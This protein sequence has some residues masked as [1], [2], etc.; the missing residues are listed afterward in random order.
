MYFM[1]KVPEHGFS[2]FKVGDHTVTHGPDGYDVS[3]GFT[4]H[5]FRLKSN[6]QN[7]VF[8][9]VV[10]SYRYHRGLAQHNTFAFHINQGIGS[11]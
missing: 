4:Q 11:P 3:R 2:N 6:S 7:P 9:S 8:G 1:D 5:I 10:G